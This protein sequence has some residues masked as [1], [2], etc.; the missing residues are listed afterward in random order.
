M[1]G[2]PLWT[3]P[4]SWLGAMALAENIDK[5]KTTGQYVLLN[6]VTTISDISQ[7]IFYSFTGYLLID[8][9]II[10]YDAIQ[11]QYSTVENPQASDW[12]FKDISSSS[13]IK[14]YIAEAF[15]P[16]YQYFK[17]SGKVRIKNRGS[18]NTEI[19]EHTAAINNNM[20]EWQVQTVRWA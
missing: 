12:Q 15:R 7:D 8:A 18:F 5:N 20:S 11:Y 2:A 10:E 6:P 17:P 19:A 4:T 3:A 16:T 9:E 1:E 13:D 14:K